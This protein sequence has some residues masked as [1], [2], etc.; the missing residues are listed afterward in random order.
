MKG[1]AIC[2]AFVIIILAAPT[3]E[4]AFCFRCESDPTNWWGTRCAGHSDLLPGEGGS[5]CANEQEWRP[6]MFPCGSEDATWNPAG[7]DWTEYWCQ[8][9]RWNYREFICRIGGNACP[10][11]EY[12]MGAAG[13]SDERDAESGCSATG[14]A[15]SG[16]SMPDRDE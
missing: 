4:A 9:G 2:I 14:L 11:W 15:S 16:V 1:F 10:P 3:V 6:T 8:D 13:D 12:Q 5:Q 7:G